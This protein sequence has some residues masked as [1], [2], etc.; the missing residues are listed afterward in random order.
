MFIHDLLGTAKNYPVS[1]D[2][3]G[4]SMMKKMLI[5]DYIY[6][7][8]NSSYQFGVQCRYVSSRARGK[9]DN[10][11]EPTNRSRDHGG[12]GC[13]RSA[14][15]LISLPR[16][17]LLP[18]RLDRGPP[19][20]ALSARPAALLY[21]RRSRGIWAPLRRCSCLSVTAA[22]LTT[23]LPDFVGR[24]PSSPAATLGPSS[25]AVLVPHD[26]C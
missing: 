18:R 26:G 8:R 21:C 13:V 3:N 1:S 6:F 25:V 9:R 23:A 17:P 20:R 12:D 14:T 24:P 22:R 10:G 15:A 7:Y 16:P 19:P 2:P 5:S 11:S 4:E